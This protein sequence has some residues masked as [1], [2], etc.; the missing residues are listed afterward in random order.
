M[1]GE[2]KQ[3]PREDVGALNN[4]FTM[5]FSDSSAP[6]PKLTHNTTRSIDHQAELTV[7]RQKLPALLD[8]RPRFGGA[9]DVQ[10]C[11]DPLT[12]ADDQDLVQRFRYRF[13]T[14]RFA[15]GTAHTG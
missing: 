13:L 14:R 3:H 9:R 12:L 1:H 5:P 4:L 2:E 7:N 6:Q 11:R 15:I 10:P 8:P